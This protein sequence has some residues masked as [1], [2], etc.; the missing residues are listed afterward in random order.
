[1]TCRAARLAVLLVWW[2]G[3]QLMLAAHGVEHACAADATDHEICAECVALAG[4]QGAAPAA[5]LHMP[6]PPVSEAA[7]SCAV[8]PEPV[9]RRPLPFLSRAPPVLP[10]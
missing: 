1:M 2:L 9:F 8:L 4:L 10:S 6:P 7:L 3:L 5:A